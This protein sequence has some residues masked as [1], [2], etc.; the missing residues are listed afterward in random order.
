MKGLFKI[1]L[2]Q[3]ERETAIE[4]DE[5][6]HIEIGIVKADGTGSM[7]QKTNHAIDFSGKG[8]HSII[9]FS[10]LEFEVNKEMV[11]TPLLIYF[12]SVNQT[13]DGGLMGP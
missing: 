7:H 6:M 9:D 2:K 10:V 13:H 4:A 11:D 3:P 12:R 8:Q 1:M 5:S